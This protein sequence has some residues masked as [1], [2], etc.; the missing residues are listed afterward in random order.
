MTIFLPGDFLGVLLGVF[1]KVPCSRGFLGVLPD[2]IDELKD[3]FFDEFKAFDEF[4][5]LRHNKK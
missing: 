2:D 1:F 5:L 4:K 3:L